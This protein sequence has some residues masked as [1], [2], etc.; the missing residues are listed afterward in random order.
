MAISTSLGAHLAWIDRVG[1][2]RAE[3]GVYNFAFG[4]WNLVGTTGDLKAT[5]WLAANT[6]Y[7]AT[8]VAAPRTMSTEDGRPGWIRVMLATLQVGGTPGNVGGV[9]QQFAAELSEAPMVGA[10]R[11]STA[12]LPASITVA[13]LTAA[14]YRVYGVLLP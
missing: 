3:V 13:S 7:T 1:L 4:Q 11:T 12:S 9:N 8:L 5:L 14:P 10:Q 6:A 2:T